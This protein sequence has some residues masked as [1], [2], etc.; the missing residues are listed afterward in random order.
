MPINNPLLVQR[1]I[2]LGLMEA[3]AELQAFRGSLPDAAVTKVANA[4]GRT[5]ELKA[6]VARPTRTPGPPAPSGGGAAS[7]VDWR[8]RWGWGGA[9][10]LG[11][12]PDYVG[13]AYGYGYD[14]YDVPDA[15]AVAGAEGGHVQ[16]CLS[17]YRS[18]DP[19][20]DTFIGYD[21]FRHPCVGPY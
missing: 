9:F 10:A 1:R 15:Y 6:P 12:G 19:A 4:L 16:Y 2:E 7:S 5:L 20:T 18:Y 13:P 14:T 17:R 3:P 21:G 8:N 11:V